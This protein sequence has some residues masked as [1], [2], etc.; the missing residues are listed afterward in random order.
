MAINRQSLQLPLK[1]SDLTFCDKKSNISSV[2]LYYKLQVA[3][4][5]TISSF[6]EHKHILTYR[7]S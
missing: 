1:I 2:W 3:P 6:E 5:F 7:Y 4:A